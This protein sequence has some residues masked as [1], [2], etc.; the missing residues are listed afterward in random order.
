VA[1]KKLKNLKKNSSPA[2][3]NDAPGHFTSQK[4]PPPSVI[5]HCQIADRPEGSFFCPVCQ[6]LQFE[7][8]N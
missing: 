6:Q 3:P 1:Q 2:S 5:S 8:S 4:S 7:S